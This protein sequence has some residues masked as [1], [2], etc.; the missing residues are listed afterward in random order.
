MTFCPQKTRKMKFGGREVLRDEFLCSHFLTFE[1][2]DIRFFQ[3]R[4]ECP[5]TTSG[6]FFSISWKMHKTTRIFVFFAERENID[7]VETPKM[8]YEDVRYG[9][10]K[11]K[12]H[13]F[14]L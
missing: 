6:Y 2:Y 11:P 13:T 14:H 7:I 4:A 9:F 5:H 3:N 8:W 12:G 10:G 1:K